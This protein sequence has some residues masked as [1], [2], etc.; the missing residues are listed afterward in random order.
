MRAIDHQIRK[1]QFEERK[2]QQTIRR[3]AAA[4]DTYTVRTLAKELVRSRKTTERL[5]SS[6]AQINSCIMEL[7]TNMATIR[8]TGALGQS[9]SLLTAMNSLMAVPELQSS[10][11]SMSREMQRAGMIESMVDDTMEDAFGVEG[12]EELVDSEVQRVIDELTVNQLSQMGSVASTP[13]P[14]RAQA[15][16]AAV[17]AQPQ[18]E[19][20]MDALSKRLAGL[21]S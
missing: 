20:E 10:L 19:E 18:E 8:V 3:A 7:N 21:A 2:V 6:K 15:A 12:E 9:A 17:H 11:K 14:A 16:T 13:L 4:N 1:I 5:H